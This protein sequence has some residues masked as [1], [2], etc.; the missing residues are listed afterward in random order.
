MKT[1]ILQVKR[2][3]GDGGKSMYCLRK[4]VFQL[5][6]ISRINLSWLIQKC[7]GARCLACL[8]GQNVVGLSYD[9]D[10]SDKVVG[11]FFRAC[12][13]DRDFLARS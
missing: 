7:D 12:R 9:Q 11:I 8:S 10:G 13:A 5:G 2:T 6:A 4:Q 3:I 1:H